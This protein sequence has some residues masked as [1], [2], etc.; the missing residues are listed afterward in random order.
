MSF[1]APSLTLSLVR[2]RARALS[3]HLHLCDIAILRG[4]LSVEQHNLK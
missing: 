1:F 2:A 3:E 4:R